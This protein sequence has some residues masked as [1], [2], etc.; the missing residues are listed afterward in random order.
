MNK[1][2]LTLTLMA[3]VMIMG[4]G[5]R[6]KGIVDTQGVD[7]QQYRRD[8]FECQQYAEQVDPKA[9]KGAVAGAV[10]GGAI[11]GV[12][13]GKKGAQ[14]GAGVGAI[15]GLAK[16]G[17]KTRREKSQVVKNCMRGRGYNVLN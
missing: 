2:M 16:G 3:L 11:G 1:V 8:L 5:H 6:H 4:C 7:M 10:I 12:L 13:D 17:A 14:K 9:A 15:T